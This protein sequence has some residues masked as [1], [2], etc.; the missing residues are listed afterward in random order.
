MEK[1]PYSLGEVLAVAETHPFY[2]ED[3][4]YPLDGKAI[5]ELREKAL[6]DKGAEEKLN[7]WPIIWKKNL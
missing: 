4:Q 2:K 3:V 1:A 5:E 7:T 6:K